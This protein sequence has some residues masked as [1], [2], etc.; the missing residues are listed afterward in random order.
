MSTVRSLN[1]ASGLL[2]RHL[3]TE[4]ENLAQVFLTTAPARK[5][6][7]SRRTRPAVVSKP[8]KL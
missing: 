3:A 6:D 7:L 5:I 8:A 4:P 2:P 1:L